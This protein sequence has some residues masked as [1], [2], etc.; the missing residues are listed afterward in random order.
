V[1]SDPASP[2]RYPHLHASLDL[3]TSGLRDR[4][5]TPEGRESLAADVRAV[6]LMTDLL[7]ARTAEMQPGKDFEDEAD[8]TSK[9]QALADAGVTILSDDLQWEPRIARRALARD[10]LP[11]KPAGRCARAYP[12]QSRQRPR[13][14]PR[15]HR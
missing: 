7:Q 6:R 10:A 14:A 4:L 13:T 3:P 2:T 12:Y 1:P 8:F 15:A 5:S 9:I 11:P